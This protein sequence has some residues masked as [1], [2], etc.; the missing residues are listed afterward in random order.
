MTS[1]SVASLTTENQQRPLI[2]REGWLWIVA[3]GGL[4]VLLHW[5]ILRRMF[6]IALDD[7]DWSHAL[8]I[9]AI[10]AFYIY[11][12]RYKL[13][14]MRRRLCWWGLPLML[15]GLFGFAAGIYP[16]RNDMAQGYSMILTLMGLAL[17]LLGPRMMTILW[18]PV[19]YLIFG[20]KVSERIWGRLAAFLQLVAAECATAV[21]QL[22]AAIS[23]YFTV[24]VEGS[25]ITL[26]IPQT[27]N[28]ITRY[29]PEKL[30][31]AEACAGLRMLMAF[32]A[33]GVALAWL[34]E[35]PWWQRII[36]V[37][38]AVPIAVA[39]NVG[40]VTILGLLYLYDPEMAAGDFHT[41]V[42]MLMLIPA[43]MLFL[44]LGWVLDRIIIKDKSKRQ[45]ASVPTGPAMRDEPR[46]TGVKA[47]TGRLVGIVLAGIVTALVG[48]AV[49]YVMV[50]TLPTGVNIPGLPPVF[51]AALVT[52]GWLLLPPMIIGTAVGLA[53]APRLMPIADAMHRDAR[54]TLALSFVAALLATGFVAQTT[55][56][57]AT[58]TVLH[59]K[60]VPLR[61]HVFMIPEAPPWKMVAEDPPLP[62]EIIEE[63]G[64]REYIS[65]TYEDPTWPEGEPGRLARLHV[66]YY[67]GT[68]D[69]VPHV[70]ERCFT[71]AGATF[72]DKSLTQL[73]IAGPQYM[74]TDDG[75]VEA[76]ST[77]ANDEVTV[78]ETDIRA[79]IFR[80]ADANNPERVQNVIYFFAANG[81][82]L[83]GSYEV[84]AAGFD[85]KDEYAYYCK[86]E[87]MIPG[88]IDQDHMAQRTG[89]FLSA[90][91]PEIMAALPDWDA[92]RA[93]E[94]PD[95]QK[96]QTHE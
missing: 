93:G 47:S 9:P 59:K 96:P 78:P 8:V 23:G 35:R 58:Q 95:Q 27:I 82:Y 83:A 91:L 75:R 19:A 34:W 73:T 4:F 68:A 31:V 72:V 55:V 15:F 1:V 74:S 26:G 60:A 46:L 21:L 45:G 63:L 42:G 80:Y 22:C 48:G 17:L 61:E 50:L 11:Q 13:A 94:W 29:V 44:L 14:A 10:S 92:V 70:P 20:I 36:M 85:P 56:V 32:L 33:L 86:I 79:S 71:A 51:S 6:F 49:Y 67:T 54:L 16:I 38:L 43:A 28:G 84:R 64:T 37:L 2:S 3:L 53:V 90:M 41:F 12:Q 5:N 87:V 89:E 57:A 76:Y 7:N 18:F 52:V 66:A 62:P 24:A 30:N 77:L 39:V 40:R 25:T 65:R 69:T 88:M 81:K